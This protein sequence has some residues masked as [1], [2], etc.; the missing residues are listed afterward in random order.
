MTTSHRS[1]RVPRPRHSPDTP[2]WGVVYGIP[3]LAVDR[4][5]GM[6]LTSRRVVVGYIGQ[7]RQTVKQREE[8]HRDGRFGDLIVGGSF[9][10]A[11]GRFTDRQLDELEQRYIREGVSLVPG[12]PPQRPVY[13]HDH[14]LDNPDRIEVWRAEEHRRARQPDWTPAGGTRIP[15]QRSAGWPIR[16]FRRSRGRR[17]RWTRTRI[18]AVSGTALWLATAIVSWVWLAIETSIPWPAVLLLAAAA[19]S[20]LVGVVMPKTRRRRGRRR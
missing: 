12:E 17:R 5:T 9:V 14:N 19:A 20:L 15:R 11:E 2:R 7:S 16:L 18:R 8:Q 4:E 3:C 13:N 6:P 1:A 10:I